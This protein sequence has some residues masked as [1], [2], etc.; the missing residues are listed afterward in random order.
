MSGSMA[1]GAMKRL[2]GNMAHAAPRPFPPHFGKGPGLVSVAGARLLVC[3]RGLRSAQ[4][5]RHIG[6]PSFSRLLTSTLVARWLTK[7]GGVVG[8]VSTGEED[9]FLGRFQT[10]PNHQSPS[11]P[12]SQ[13]PQRRA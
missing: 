10:P 7:H 3:R 2:S 5:G 4:A 1:T 11:G 6:I 8:R 12:G 13:S 9:P